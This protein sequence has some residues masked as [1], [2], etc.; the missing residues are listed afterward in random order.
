MAII[1]G[2]HVQTLYSQAFLSHLL[3]QFPLYPD[4]STQFRN[5]ISKNSLQLLILWP[6][7]LARVG[8]RSNFDCRSQLAFPVVGTL[9]I[10]LQGIYVGS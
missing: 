5:A 7:T 3:T 10:E 2:D 6:Q 4:W 1:R 8:C 9:V